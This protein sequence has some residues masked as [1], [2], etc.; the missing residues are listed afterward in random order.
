MRVFDLIREICK[1][2]YLVYVEDLSSE[3]NLNHGYINHSLSQLGV[4]REP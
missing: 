2:V 4:H 1:P 3:N